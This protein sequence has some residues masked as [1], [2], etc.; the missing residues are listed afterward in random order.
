MKTILRNFT[1]SKKGRTL[2]LRK[3]C[4]GEELQSEKVMI[5]KDWREENFEEIKYDDFESLRFDPI[6]EDNKWEWKSA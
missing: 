1:N 5:F 6:P 2:N 3:S 4:V